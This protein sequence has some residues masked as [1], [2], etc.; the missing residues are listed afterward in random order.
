MS[1]MPTLEF[2][3]QSGLAEQQR[4]QRAA[5]GLSD[6]LYFCNYFCRFPDVNEDEHGE[7]I[8]AYE[9]LLKT[10]SKRRKRHKDGKTTPND[11]RKLTLLVRAARGTLK[12]SLDQAFCMR[13]I[14]EDPHIAIRFNMNKKENAE[15]KTGTIGK[16]LRFGR[17][18]EHYGE[19]YNAGHWSKGE[20]QS[21]QAD[22]DADPTVIAGGLDERQTG[23]HCDVLINS[24][25]Q[26]DDNTQTAVLREN[27]E[28]WRSSE[29]SLYRQN[30]I[31]R[32]EIWDCTVWNKADIGCQM[33]EFAKSHPDSISSINRPVADIAEWMAN[34]NT[35]KMNFNRLFPREKVRDL[36]IPEISGLRE[37]DVYCQYFLDASR[38][39]HTKF[40]SEW[41]KCG[42]DYDP[43]ATEYNENRTNVCLLPKRMKLYVTIDPAD[44][45]AIRKAR[46]KGDTANIKNL[47]NTGMVLW[48]MDEMKRRIILEAISRQMSVP[49]MGDQIITWFRAY[50]LPDRKTDDKA[51]PK[52]GATDRAQRRWTF[53]RVG[54]EKVIFSAGAI[55]NP[56]K[57][58]LTM[59]PAIGP[60]WAKRLLN[61]RSAIQIST[62]RSKAGRQDATEVDWASGRV[63]IGQQQR[64]LCDSS[65]HPAQTLIE[66]KKEYPNVT[67]WDVLDAESLGYGPGFMAA[68]NDQPSQD[69]LWAK[70]FEKECKAQLAI[71]SGS[72]DAVN[73]HYMKAFK[74]QKKTGA[75]N[76]YGPSQ[77]VGVG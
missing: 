20:L 58:Y 9:K 8:A 49:E 65:E 70:K 15:N 6:F 19:F 67:D 12:T 54:V 17:I 1:E 26:D 24:D 29:Q 47:C 37:F 71:Q 44:A 53:R 57:A 50:H 62:Q 64:D 59:Q 18:P 32:I 27:A 23:T 60:D 16:R 77:F 11:M 73:A 42:P 52:F 13:L 34:S 5:R 39:E 76:M 72:M 28:Q 7:T 46:E 75:G 41:L 22:G 4:K 2:S 10:I 51:L 3:V 56:L 68:P 35:A 45:E 31:Y 38:N 21:K 55:I 36:F 63:R 48:G 69:E 40:K 14:V 74:D 43:S 61:D 25:C 30:S 66:A 33:H